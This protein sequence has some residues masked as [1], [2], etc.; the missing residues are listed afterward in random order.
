ML[1]G[2]GERR[3]CNSSTNP[4][5]IEFAGHGAQ[6]RLDIAEALAMCQLRKCHAQPLIPT[7]KSAQLPSCPVTRYA[8]LKLGVR[9]ELHQLGKYGSALIHTSMMR[10]FF[11]KWSSNVEIVLARNRA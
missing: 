7:R 9:Q 6:T 11:P 1:V 8:P 2:I 3:P 5:M 4:E 10:I